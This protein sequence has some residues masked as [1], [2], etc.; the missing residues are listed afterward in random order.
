MESKSDISFKNE[1][2]G[3]KFNF[4]VAGLFMDDDKIL[5]QKCDKDSYYSLAG[6]RVQFFEDTKEA[7]IREIKEELGITLKNEDLFLIDIVENFFIHDD[8]KVHEM[9][10]IY[11]ISNIKELANKKDLRILDKDDAICNWFTKKEIQNINIMPKIVKDI[12]NNKDIKH[13][14][15]KD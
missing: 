14:I 9:L 7:L 10:Y 15:I 8:K 4:R 11:K 12:L 13:H 6:G 1:E 5:L 3:I 2:L